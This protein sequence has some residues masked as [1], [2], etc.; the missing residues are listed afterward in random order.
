M[1]FREVLMR[2]KTQ[3][4]RA[5]QLRLFPLSAP[6]RWTEVPIEARAR[7]VR[8]LAHLLRE[9]L[10]ACRDPEVRDE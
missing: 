4:Q 8:L 1:I 2:S 5:N 10:R 3:R 7:A 9:H 6:L